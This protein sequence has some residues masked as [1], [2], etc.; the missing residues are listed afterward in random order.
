MLQI[1]E[2]YLKFFTDA[3]NAQCACAQY[4]RKPKEHFFLPKT[5]TL[6]IDI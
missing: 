3:Y 5:L 6:H 2:N 1:F 4:K